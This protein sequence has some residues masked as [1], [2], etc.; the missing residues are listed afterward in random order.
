MVYCFS[1]SLEIADST[2][3]RTKVV[4]SLLNDAD[5]IIT[6]MSCSNQMKKSGLDLL[7]M[8][9]WFCSLFVFSVRS[10]LRLINAGYFLYVKMQVFGFAYLGPFGHFLHILLDKLFQGKKDKK[11][12]A[13]KV[14]LGI[15]L[16][17]VLNHCLP[18]SLSEI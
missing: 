11:T 7:I 4:V 2:L 14:P 15:L 12:V 18:S 10:M 16:L 1:S 6:V 17:V 5:L 9:L 13:K 3:T 8:D